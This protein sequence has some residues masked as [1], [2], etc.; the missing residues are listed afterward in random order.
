[1]I[2]SRIRTALRMGI[3]LRDAQKQSSDN[4]VLECALDGVVNGAAVEIIRSLGLEPSYLSIYRPS[5]LTTP[6]R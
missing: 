5:S 4:V 1:M 6:A 3:M 2:C